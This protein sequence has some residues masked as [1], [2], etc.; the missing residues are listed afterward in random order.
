MNCAASHFTL[1]SLV[2]F[3]PRMSLQLGWLCPGKPCQGVGLC[4]CVLPAAHHSSA[5]WF[6]GRVPYPFSLHGRQRCWGSALHGLGK[7]HLHP[8]GPP[9][10]QWACLGSSTCSGAVPRQ[11]PHAVGTMLP[12]C[13][14]SLFRGL[15]ALCC[16]DLGEDWK[17]D[18]IPTPA[19]SWD[20]FHKTRLLRAPSISVLSWTPPFDY[21]CVMAITADSIFLMCLHSSRGIILFLWGFFPA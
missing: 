11:P 13:A 1:P 20:T 15:E 12:L 4:L 18:L 9:K 10:L 6:L 16:F 3:C 7:E 8:R 2:F 14:T 17:A 19:I 21:L 5:L